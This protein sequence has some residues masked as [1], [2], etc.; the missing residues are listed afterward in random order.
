MKKSIFVLTL[1]SSSV[2][3]GQSDSSYSYRQD[4]TAKTSAYFAAT[5]KLERKSPPILSGIHAVFDETARATFYT[6]TFSYPSG[7]INTS[8]PTFTW[9]L[10]APKD[11]KAC[12]KFQ[13]SA[14][15]SEAAVWFH[16]SDTDGC[17]HKTL[18]HQGVVSLKVTVTL[19]N[20]SR[21]WICNASYFGTLTGDGDEALCTIEAG[22]LVAVARPPKDMKQAWRDAAAAF[23]EMEAAYKITGNTAALIA[24]IPPATAVAGPLAVVIKL[25]GEGSSYAMK[26]LSEHKAK[27]PADPNFEKIAKVTL[28]SRILRIP[29]KSGLPAVVIQASNALAMNVAHTQAQ[30]QAFVTSINRMS[31]AYVAKNAAAQAMQEHAAAAFALAIAKLDDERPALRLSFDEALVAAGVN[32]FFLTPEEFSSV[33]ASVAELGLP[34]DFVAQLRNSG[35]TAKEVAKFQ[36]AIV[37][38]KPPSDSI[39]LYPYSLTSSA[40][41]ADLA[42]AN[43]MRTYATFATDNR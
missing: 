30:T 18:F 21:P 4:E 8:E 19:S 1:L 13:T 12:N 39:T 29:A 40:I 41:A 33:Q 36:E 25:V 35:L 31:G 3:A 34:A 23:G 14:S 28:P 20:D 32:S 2:L 7:A 43:L 16:S 6:V 17:T 42:D 15:T 38:A 26:T 11:D 24:L 37:T 27:D 9:Q 22:A 5:P 10:E